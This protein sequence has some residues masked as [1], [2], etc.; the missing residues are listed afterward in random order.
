MRCKHAQ[1][2]AGHND[3]FR[4]AGIDIQLLGLNALLHS[5]LFW[6]VQ[7]PSAELES[8]PRDF[9]LDKLAHAAASSLSSSAITSLLPKDARRS[10]HVPVLF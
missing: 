2:P 1:I 8:W 5:L 9:L 3:W 6:N 10:M 7:P 4:L